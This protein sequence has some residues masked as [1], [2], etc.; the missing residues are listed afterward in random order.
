MVKKVTLQFPEVK[1]YEKDAP[2]YFPSID[3]AILDAKQLQKHLPRAIEIME[4]I[5]KNPAQQMSDLLKPDE[6]IYMKAKT[7]R[8]RVWLVPYLFIHEE[9]QQ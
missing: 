3:R 2:R 6:V 1:S 7:K 8:K 9:D 4:L 5:E